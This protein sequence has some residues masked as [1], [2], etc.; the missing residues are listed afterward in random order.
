MTRE[1]IMRLANT[2]IEALQECDDGDFVDAVVNAVCCAYTFDEDE[3]RDWSEED[4]QRRC[5]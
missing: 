3:V 2:L 5:D 4:D 1:E